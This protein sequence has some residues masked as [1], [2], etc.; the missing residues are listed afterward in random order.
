[1]QPGSFVFMDA[2]YADTEGV[3]FG[4]ALLAYATVISHPAPGRIVVDAGL[5]ALSTDS[6]PARLSPHVGWD[7]A[8]AGDEHGVLTPAADAPAPLRIGDR[9]A[10]QPSHIDT[11]VNLYDMLHAHRGGR[12]EASWSV[13]ARG[14]SQ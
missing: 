2:D 8:A 5:K 10:L 12:I 14:R 9:V 4:P 13:A 7:Y 11:T 1:V 6:G 3:A